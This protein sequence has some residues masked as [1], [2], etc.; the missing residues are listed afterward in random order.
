MD[1]QSIGKTKGQGWEIGARRTFPISADQAWELMVTQPGMSIWFGDDPDFKIEKGASFQTSDGTTGH[2][3]SFK[4]GSLLRMRWQPQGF[5]A[6]STLQLR[7]IP[8]GAKATISIHHERLADGT[9]RQTMKQHWDVVLN[10]IQA[11]INKES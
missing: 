8:A 7:I 6:P 5:D 10:D 9:Q 1:S 3:V 4:E 11:L 2:I